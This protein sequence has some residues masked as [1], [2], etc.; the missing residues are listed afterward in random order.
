MIEI[1]ENKYGKSRVRLVQVKRRDSCHDLREWTVDVLLQGDFDSCF[2][3]GDNSKILPTDTM[4]NTVYSLARNSAATCMEDFAKELIDFL[5]HRNP[6]VAAAE[7]S[8][9]EKPWE[10][11]EIGEKPHPTTFIQ[12][13]SETQTTKVTRTRTTEFSVTA[14]FE[15]IVIM[16]TANSA[17]E[18]YIQDSLTT[19]PPAKDRLLGTAVSSSWNYTRPDAAFNFLRAKVREIL[20]ATFAAHKSKSVQ[21]TL[22]A[23]G[24]AVLEE[25]PAV[26]D[27]E[28]AM[29][30]KHCLLV[31]LSR[32]GQDNP[33]EIF[34]PVDE[35][36]GNIQARLRR[37]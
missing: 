23:M 27:I 31:D 35:P 37:Q 26:E 9:S 11:L 10:H 36:H 7:V 6:Q 1:V 21:H 28:L 22:Y 13:A 34:V 25:I 2:T 5:L 17:F 18:G 3:E 8:I 20:L 14:G 33:N 15:N 4:K 29:P 32:F 30:N 19:L 24:K 16:K 12:S